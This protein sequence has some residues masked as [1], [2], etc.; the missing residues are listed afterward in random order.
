MKK[1]Q[2]PEHGRGLI[3]IK[4]TTIS[5]IVSGEQKRGLGKFLQS[6]F[7]GGVVD[8]IDLWDQTMGRWQSH[9]VGY[10][11]N[12]FSI[13]SWKGYFLNVTDGANLLP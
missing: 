2:Q 4:Y 8:Q 11:F 13:E 12:D 9:K 5:L 10:S 6:P 3:S 1:S 7:S